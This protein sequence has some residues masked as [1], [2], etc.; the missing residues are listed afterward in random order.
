[1]T[2]G[3]FY[4]FRFIMHKHSPASHL[5]R[6]ITLLYED[7]DVLVIGKAEG[8]LSTPTRNHEPFTAEGALTN[9]LRKGCARS[10]K[11]VFLVHRLDRETSG[12]MIFAKTFEAQQ[13]LKDNWKANEKIYYAIIRGHLPEKKGVLSCYLAEDEDQY[14][15]SVETIEEGK[16]AETE[17]EVVRER[18]EMSLLRIRLLTGRKNQIRVQFSECGYPVLGDEKY[19]TPESRASRL[20]L[21]AFSIAFDQ[22]RTKKRLRFELPLP[23]IF[24]RLFPGVSPAEGEKAA[25]PR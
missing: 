10:T 9:Y 21:H 17:Y 15:H 22:P 7:A 1:M 12:V 20:C 25:Q 14:V 18:P 6:G 16:L 24:N 11:H 13:T 23:P 3:N 2:G 4:P 5:P 8:I 19:G